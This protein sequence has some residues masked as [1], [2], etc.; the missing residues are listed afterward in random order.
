M[1]DNLTTQSATPATIPAG[2]KIATREVTYSGD[3]SSHLAPVA[4][5]TLSGADDAKTATD[6]SED[7]GIPIAGEAVTDSY[8]NPAQIAGGKATA[9]VDS[10]GNLQVRGPVTTDEQGWR[11]CFSGSSVGLALTGTPTFTNGGTSVTGSGTLFTTEVEAGDYI[12][13]DSDGNTAWARV[14]EVLSDT[15]LTLE[16]NYSGTSGGSASSVAT[17]AQ[18]TGTGGSITVTNSAM[19]IVS[20][21]TISAET[22]VRRVVDY[23]PMVFE[24]ADV[25]LSQRIANQTAYL[26]LQHRGLTSTSRYYARFEFDGTSN[27]VVKCASSW[28]KSGSLTANDIQSTTAT[29]PASLTTATAARYRIELAVLYVRFYVNDILLAEHRTHLPNPYDYVDVVAYWANGGSAPATSTNFVINSMAVRNI[30]KLDVEITSNV[31]SVAVNNAPAA[32]LTGSGAA[33]NADLII[34]DCLQYRGIAVQVTSIGGG[35][36]LSFQGSNDSA[37]GA[38]IALQAIPAAGGA[39]VT[40]TNAVGHWIIPIT[41]RFVRVRATAFTSGTQTIT[42]MAMQQM[43]QILPQITTVYNGTQTVTA[44][45]GTGGTAATSLG[46][47]EDAV[48]ATGDTGVAVLAVRRDT[49][50]SDVSA[51]GDYATLQVNSTGSLWV[52]PVPTTAGGL[53]IARTISAATTNATSVKASAG[54]V[55]GWY[56]SNANA[57]ARFLKL[58]NKASAPTVGTDTPVMTIQIPAGAAANVEF[59]HGIAFA[60]GIALALTANVADADTSAVAANEI[61]INLLYK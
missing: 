59:S 24:A 45:L 2:A 4:L 29:L 38:V 32:I 60:T 49:P 30:N 36:T 25:S 7:N 13:R 43:P 21:T 20:G 18:F 27:T 5:V 26:G 17:V 55:F 6:I 1:A 54:Q 47:A 50:T 31:D 14:D 9:R 53:T 28:T 56:I 39:A 40:T 52:T 42:V 12:K 41:T 44:N 34:L 10:F 33:L 58:Y 61:I 35:A 51:A 15:A 23:A 48:A 16:A 19:T 3:T 46:K 8:P 37:F 57:A 11:D 22:G